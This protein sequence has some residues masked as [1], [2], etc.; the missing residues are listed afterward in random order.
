MGVECEVNVIA[1]GVLVLQKS[2]ESAKKL[3]SFTPY[4]PLAKTVSLIALK[5]HFTLSQ[6]IATFNKIFLI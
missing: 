1:G 4:K 2:T 5:Y 6:R 3:G